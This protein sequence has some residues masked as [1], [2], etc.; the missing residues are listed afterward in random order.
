M[1]PSQST[2]S[3]SS[4]PRASSRI[5]TVGAFQLVSRS[6][7][8]AIVRRCLAADS[9]SCRQRVVATED[10][11][12]TWTDITPMRTTPGGLTPDLML[13]HPFFLD[14]E[15]GWVT[16]NDCAGGKAV[17]F[18]TASG[19][20]RWARTSIPP[21]TCNAGAGTTPTFVDARHGWLVHLEP[22]GASASIQ[23][24]TDGGKTWSRERVFSWITGVRFVD[25]LDGWLAGSNLPG[26][27]G[28]FETANGGRTWARDS[29]PLPS[30][31]RNWMP[32]FDAPTFFGTSQ[33]VVPVTLRD[34]NRSVVAF[35]A[36]ADGGRTWRVAAA[37]PPVGAGASGFP[38]PASVSIATP[39]DWWVLAGSPPRLRRTSDAGRTWLPI[40]IPK[41]RRA[42]A[43][44]AVDARHAWIRVLDGRMATLLATRDGGRTWSV[45]TPLA[46]PNRP[47]TS[48]AF[49]TVLPLPGPV[50]AVAPGENGII[51]A[52][53]LPHPNGDRQVIVRF[54]PATGAVER[55]RPIPGAQGG[56]DRLA[57]TG[58]TLWAS[59]GPRRILYRLDARNLDVRERLA[60]PGPTGPLAAV[61]AGL[62]TA[63]GRSIVL[64][65]PE[66]GEVITSVTFRGRVELLVADPT[67]QRLYASTTAPVRHDATPILE[68]DAT[69]GEILARAWRCCADL[70]GPSGLSATILG[71]WVTAPTGMM[72]SLAFLRDADLHQVALF[73][74][75]GSNGLT[76][77]AARGLLWVTDL[78]GGYY[79]ADATTGR[80]LGHIGIRQA[81]SGISNIISVERRLYVGAFDGLARLRRV[82]TAAV[83]RGYVV[84]YEE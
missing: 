54:D 38:S 24:S 7:G 4:S 82:A 31:C 27:A 77:Y 80:V 22:T 49:R 28:L 48:T 1:H 10:F 47:A 8:V 20:R 37:F 58:E 84:W 29:A 50:T 23:L 45:L 66:T 60:M 76:A 64:L 43:L 15:H 42:I 52:S 73:K 21:A 34:G 72:A 39:R 81:P 44:D 11:G 32:M 69:T 18:R 16:A 6:F 2:P 3:V 12:R 46:R 5:T 35:D 57:A 59:A 17:L 74:P 70:N 36:T 79:C 68:L 25:P 40:A 13:L 33:A 75:G 62:W 14:P 71:V 78:L 55:S 63:A 51:F 65:D 53:Y 41:A 56:V 61:P 83:D 67:D 19:G 26:E 30:C 9:S